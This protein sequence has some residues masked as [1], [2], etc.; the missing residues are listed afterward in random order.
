MEKLNGKLEDLQYAMAHAKS[1]TEA[2]QIKGEIDRTRKQI[3][4]T[5]GALRHKVD[6]TGRLTDLADIRGYQPQSASSRARL[7]EAERKIRNESEAVRRMRVELVKATRSGD[8]D[9]V[10]NITELMQSSAK[11]QNG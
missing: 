2:H 6:P 9:K 1:I 10:R 5:E 8:T 7:A 4:E 3:Q 11:Y